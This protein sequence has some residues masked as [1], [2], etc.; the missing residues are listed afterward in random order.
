[1]NL[2]LLQQELNKG[3]CV[4]NLKEMA[5]VCYD[6]A[7]AEDSPTPFYVLHNILSDIASHWDERPL[8][9]KEAERVEA[10][11]LPHIRSVVQG[12]MNGAS[13]EEIYSR[14]DT[15]IIRTAISLK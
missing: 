1:M 4:N 13:K 10:E 8:L 2:C 5:R 15:L 7:I 14:L 11:L 6:L 3:L 9:T 12:L